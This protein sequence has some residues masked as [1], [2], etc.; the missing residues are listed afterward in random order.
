MLYYLIIIQL[1]V[2]SSCASITLDNEYVNNEVS[3][4]N[5]A[6]FKHL[7]VVALDSNLKTQDKTLSLNSYKVE[8]LLVAELRKKDLG[9]SSAA[10]LGVENTAKTR[11][12]FQKEFF[13]ASIYHL[14]VW[15]YF[16][17]NIP[18]LK[19]CLL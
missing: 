8:T 6:K 7:Y 15:P 12:L 11:D 14:K 1:F 16:L 19:C 2:F 10:N 17:K 5:S 9:A 4:K 18:K 3:F 13:S